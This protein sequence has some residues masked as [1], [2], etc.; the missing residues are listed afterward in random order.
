MIGIAA[1]FLCFCAGVGAATQ[2]AEPNASEATYGGGSESN[3]T[4]NTDSAAGG[5]A[6]SSSGEGVEINSS[7][8]ASNEVKIV[9][10]AV[11]AEEEDPEGDVGDID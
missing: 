5:G 6:P 10:A 7:V 4:E 2:F 11:P 3:S 8:L 9:V 1:V